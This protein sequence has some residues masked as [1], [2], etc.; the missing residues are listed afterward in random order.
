MRN[1]PTQKS[2]ENPPFQEA[3][4]PEAMR[5][6][7]WRYRRELGREFGLPELLK[8]EDIRAKTRLVEAL[9]G[10]PTDSFDRNV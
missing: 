2:G 9:Q 1:R 3:L 10:M 6:K 8:L 7:L 4:E 5:K